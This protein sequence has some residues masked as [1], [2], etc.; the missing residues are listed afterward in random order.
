MAMGLI[1]TGLK[2][3]VAVKVGHMVHDR[4]QQR[5]QGQ[6][7]AGGHPAGIP[8]PAGTPQA[9]APVTQESLAPDAA[10][11]PGTA[12]P[13]DDVLAR[14]TQLG[15]L[16]A[17]GILTEAEFQAQKARILNATARGTDRNGS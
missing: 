7:A 3:A 1:K 13:A 14:L 11:V 9:S 6:W 10:A 4:I 5:Q 17:A 15:E 2:A 16:K 12:A 8:T